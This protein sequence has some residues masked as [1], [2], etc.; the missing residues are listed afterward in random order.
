MK[1]KKP[2]LLRLS[3]FLLAISAALNMTPA[4]NAADFIN[5]GFEDTDTRGWTVTGGIWTGTPIA[6]LDPATYTSAGGVTSMATTAT[7]DPYIT[8][9]NSIN[10]TTISPVFD[11]SY[12][13]KI[14]DA[15]SDQGVTVISQS[16]TNYV[17]NKIY[18]AWLAVLEGSHDVTDSDHFVI[19]VRNTT[20]NTDVQT[21]SYS[22]ANTA[23]FFTELTGANAGI[24]VSGWQAQ[25]IDVTQGQDYTISLL[26]ADC[27]YGGHWGYVYLDFAGS[28]A[29]TGL[30]I[31]SGQPGNT[32]N[33]VS[34]GNVTNGSG[35][36]LI[37]T[38]SNG[39]SPNYYNVFDGG[40]LTI[41]TNGQTYAGNF[42]ITSNGAR[43]DQNG[44]VVTL[45]GVFSNNSSD[46]G[47]LRIINTGSGGSVSL[48][49]V[50]TYTGS[51]TI[52][53][54]ATLIIS[55]TGVLG[56]GAY[57]GNISN[58]GTLTYSSSANQVFS[59]TISG[60]GAINKS[61]T[62]TL[63]LDGLNTFTGTTNVTGGT[64][65]VGSST[66]NSTA[67][68][69]GIVTIGASGSLAGH[70]TVGG[71]A[72]T[73]T[74][75]GTV[76]PGNN[77]VAVLNIG[78]IYSQA[79]SGNLSLDL[80]PSTNDQLAVVGLANLNGTVTVNGSSGT[81]S[82]T[83]YTLLTSGGRTGTFSTLN[84]DLSSYTTLG[85]F[86]SYDANNVYLTLG[87]DY[88]NSNR[89]INVI[90][91]QLKS[92]FAARNE[93]LLS[94]LNY[95]C[96]LFGENNICLSTGGRVTYT[97]SFT[98]KLDD[99][100][101]SS[102]SALLIGAYRA[103]KGLRIGGWVDQD[104]YTQNNNIRMS[105]SNPM[106]GLFAV[107]YPSGDNTGFQAKAS[108]SYVDKRVE[109]TRDQL[110]NTEPGQG[111]TKLKGFGSQIEFAYGF[112][113]VISSS[114]VSPFIGIRNYDSSTA[115]YSEVFS[116]NVQVPISYSK[117]SQRA[118]MAFSGLKL[119][120][121]LS[122]DLRYNVSGGLEKDVNVNNP[123]Y[124]GTSSI[125]GLNSFSQD[126]LT[127]QRESRV[128]ANLGT[129]YLL[130]KNETI[131]LGVSYRQDRFK[132]TSLVSGMLTYTIGL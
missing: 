78:G 89:S 114:V 17:S 6:P 74:N 73:L 49:G 98:D 105:N 96:N 4:V 31:T 15:S 92:I 125:Y 128:F 1:T 111:S 24:F 120:G 52:D 119:E 20:T 25:E 56:G 91:D 122:K 129:T 40:T 82:P 79:A 37:S 115:A 72:T 47:S 57:A 7:T 34:A 5:G 51:T 18:I 100:R 48:T 62:S 77:S 63:T 30:T 55:S 75:N 9:Y 53:S 43:I 102:A 23:G 44:K 58:S 10:N 126:S 86:L 65:L 12:A 116:S 118:T 54:G 81:Y 107:Y 67:R 84:G 33:I 83:R 41:D 66:N 95:D 113:D 64:L 70:G 99:N 132:G 21:I 46:T 28:V 8:Q 16:V 117:Y 60:A 90:H 127:R 39:T 38:Q 76:S 59:G 110:A 85:Y 109:I 80:T 14:N 104:L 97:N 88:E 27:P 131:S 29:P 45:S 106:L 87:P 130:E 124:S 68:L 108:L 61:S 112:D 50:N 121:K 71:S 93:S 35:I 69:L 2:R 103:D 13:V 22:S 123:T 3:P 32:P 26:A 19:K 11:G 42:T 36:N 94:G 101:P